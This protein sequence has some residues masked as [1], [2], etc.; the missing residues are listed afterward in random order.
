MPHALWSTCR[1]SLGAHQ[2][3]IGLTS[4]TTH[5][6]HRERTELPLSGEHLANEPGAARL[7]WGA[8]LECV[9]NEPGH[10]CFRV[11]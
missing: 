2:F 4:N 1:V 3:R 5:I 6:M 10:E 9:R 7:A 8:S 11:K